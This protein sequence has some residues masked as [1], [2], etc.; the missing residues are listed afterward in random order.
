MAFTHDAWWNGKK[1]GLEEV[2]EIID[3]HMEELK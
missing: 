2:L 3:K 1:Y